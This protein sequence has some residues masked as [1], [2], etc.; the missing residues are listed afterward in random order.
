VDSRPEDD[1]FIALEHHFP[2]A[3]ILFSMLLAG[4]LGS[5]ILTLV[6]QA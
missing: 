4:S 5:A 6:A 1:E 3:W 2:V